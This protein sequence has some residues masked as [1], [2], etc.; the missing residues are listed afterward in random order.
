MNIVKVSIVIPVFNTENYLADSINSILHQTLEEIEIVVVNDGSTDRSAQIL[1]EFAQKEKRMRILSHE[2]NRGLSEARNSGIREAR[3]EFIYLFDSDDILERDCLELCYHKSKTEALD[4][5]F[6]DA[7]T[8]SDSSVKTSFHPNYL[9]T[10]ALV[11]KV[12]AGI[13][14]LELLM[15]NNGYKDS[16]CLNFI[17]MSYLE[18]LNLSFVPGIYYEDV[19]FTLHLYIE[20]T[21]VGFI[22]RSFFHRRIRVNSIMM[23]MRMK[24]IIDMLFIIREI[25]RYKKTQPERVKKLLNKKS[26]SMLL[27]ILKKVLTFEFLIKTNN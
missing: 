6:F 16:V 1:E 20:A 4:F 26:R 14:I 7:V 19:L 15:S 22:N 5:L 25:Q 12:Y 8:F 2:C 24:N 21:R 27:F 10:G 23:N 3:G 11:S 13:D 9:R 18:R 17:Q